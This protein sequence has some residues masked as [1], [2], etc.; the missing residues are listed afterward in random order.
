ME[1]SAVTYRR[2]NKLRSRTCESDNSDAITISQC[3]Q[4]L[5]YN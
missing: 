2:K 1:L 3:V 5:G 4:K